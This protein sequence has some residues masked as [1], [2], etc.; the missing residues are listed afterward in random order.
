MSAVRVY[1]DFGRKRKVV[2]ISRRWE[3]SAQHLERVSSPQPSPRTDRH[4]HWHARG[5]A[6]SFE[7]GT[8]EEMLRRREESVRITRRGRPDDREEERS[9]WGTRDGAP[10]RKTHG[11]L[12]RVR[13]TLVSLSWPAIPGFKRVHDPY[14]SHRTKRGPVRE[15]PRAIARWS[16]YILRLSAAIHLS[17]WIPVA[18]WILVVLA[19]GYG[20]CVVCE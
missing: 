14:T 17:W 1:Q 12:H 8:D 13:Y 20:H 16:A 5:K 2:G 10:P 18:P 4:V 7:R 6:R 15:R 3:Q 9:S 11:H 19:A